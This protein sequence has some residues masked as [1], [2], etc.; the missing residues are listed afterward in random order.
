MIILIF[1]S[2][3]EDEGRIDSLIKSQKQLNIELNKKADTSATKILKRISFSMM[4]VI[5][6]LSILGYYFKIDRISSM[7]EC[8]KIIDYS[9]R[10]MALVQDLTLYIRNLIF[11]NEGLFPNVSSDYESQLRQNIVNSLTDFDNLNEDIQFSSLHSMAHS[12]NVPMF[13][14]DS[15]SYAIFDLNDADEQM[16]TKAYYITNMP[17]DQITFDRSE[18]YFVIYNSMNDYFMILNEIYNNLIANVQT[19]NNFISYLAL[20]FLVCSISLIFCLSL[21]NTVFFQKAYK[22]KEQI[23]T[24]FLDIPQ[25]TAKFLYSKCEN[26]LV[27]ISSGLFYF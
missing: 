10:K 6:L 26:F 22:I 25:K 23:L 1:S 13:F 14:S 2:L 16:V 27:N 5:M 4:L 9:S 8:V 7:K 11:L 19:L 18:V 17:L 12:D 21:F 15:N 20:V 24:V 3:E